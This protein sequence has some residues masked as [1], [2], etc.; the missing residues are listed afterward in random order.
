M[1]RMRFSRIT[2]VANQHVR[3]AVQ[4]RDKRAKF[5]HDA[6][7]IEGPHLLEMALNR[8]AGILTGFVGAAFIKKEEHQGFL[9]RMAG[10]AGEIFEVTE[11][12]LGKITDTETPQGIAAV[13]SYQM[14]KLTEIALQKP[15]LIVVIDSIQDPGNLGTIIRTADAAGADAVVLLP[16]TCDAFKPK[17]IRSTAGSIFNIPIVASEADA[18]VGWLR[19]KNIALAVTAGDA[20]EVIYHADFS[21]P[22][23]MAFGNEARGMSIRLR[24]SAGAA[25]RIPIFGK[26]ES[27]NVATSAAICLYE[28]VRQR[29]GELPVVRKTRE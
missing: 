9:R 29:R 8:G 24:K 19:E 11:Q 2:S 10:A 7:L 1:G 25:L 14:Q 26:A 16:G 27:L 22:L 6:F 3:D 4:I 5:R 18:L 20:E 23:A 17:T 21:G 28:I 15:P 12:V 13:V